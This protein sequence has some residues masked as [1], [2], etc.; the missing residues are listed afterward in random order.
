MSYAVSPAL[1][2]AVFQRLWPSEALRALVGIGIFD[3]APIGTVSGTY[4]TLGPEDVRDRS[5]RSGAGAEHD[6]VITVVS[7]AA[8]FQLAKSVAAEV[9]DSLQSAPLSLSR[10]RVVGLW[11]LRAAARRADKGA[12]RRVDL[13]FRARVEDN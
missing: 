13:T 7:D 10:G 5:D 3:A 8:G 2:A 11:F 4:V 6:F 9:S 12:L 1:Q